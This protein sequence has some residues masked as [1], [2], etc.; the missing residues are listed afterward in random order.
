MQN[1]AAHPRFQAKRPL[2]VEPR[3]AR[4]TLPMLLA[5]AQKF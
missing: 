3:T 5:L 2:A 1:A 4:K